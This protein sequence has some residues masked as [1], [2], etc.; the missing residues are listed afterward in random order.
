MLVYLSGS[1][2]HVFA[3]EPAEDFHPLHQALHVNNVAHFSILTTFKKKSKRQ[4]RFDAT[5]KCL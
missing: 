1:H 3:Q 5:T 2:A 4:L